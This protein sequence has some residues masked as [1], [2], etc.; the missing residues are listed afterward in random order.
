MAEIHFLGDIQPVFHSPMTQIYKDRP[1]G[2]YSVYSRINSNVRLEIMA[3][4]QSDAISQGAELLGI[5]LGLVVAVKMG[6]W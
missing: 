6:E 1:L 5:P 4:T 3:R 2:P